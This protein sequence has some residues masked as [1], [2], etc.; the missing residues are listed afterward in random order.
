LKNHDA[1]AAG[2]SLLPLPLKRSKRFQRQNRPR[3]V[4]PSAASMIMTSPWVIASRA[5]AAV[6]SAATTKSP[7]KTQMQP[8]FAEL[9]RDVVAC[10]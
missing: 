4:A 1:D 3:F 10:H 9:R 2:A 6:G 8:T 7:R 5:S